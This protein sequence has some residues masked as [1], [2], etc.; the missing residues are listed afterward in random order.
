MNQR[1]VI[2][3]KKIIRQFK[4]LAFVL[5]PC[6]AYYQQL[7]FSRKGELYGSHDANDP[8]CLFIEESEGSAHTYLSHR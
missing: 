8:S 5:I 4:W 7:L 3:Y 6:S 1:V 2:L